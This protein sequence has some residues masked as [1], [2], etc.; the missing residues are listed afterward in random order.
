MILRAVHRWPLKLRLPEWSHYDY[1]VTYEPLLLQ[2]IVGSKVVLPTCF[3]LS[4]RGRHVGIREDE[5][6][7]L[8][9]ETQAH[10][11]AVGVGVG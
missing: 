7:I 4:N 8:C 2:M 1:N 9:L 3:Y 6:R 5:G 10:A 11:Q